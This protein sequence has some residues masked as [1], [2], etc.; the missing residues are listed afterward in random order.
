MN[1]Q[2]LDTIRRAEQLAKDSGDEQLAGDLYALG[3][4][5]GAQRQTTGE[6]R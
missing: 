5:L 6:T 3:C 1:D 4:E 2:M